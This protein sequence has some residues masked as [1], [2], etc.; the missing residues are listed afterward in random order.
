[1]EEDKGDGEGSRMLIM[2]F[3]YLRAVSVGNSLSSTLMCTFLYVHYT[4]IS[5]LFL[6]KV[7]V[8]LRMARL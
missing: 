4:S 2:L 8:M 5:K 6:K 7:L 3:L 1:M